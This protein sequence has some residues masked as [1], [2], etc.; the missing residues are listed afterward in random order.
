MIKDKVMKIMELA[1][2]ICPPEITD[3]GMN[4]TAAFV[5]Y[6]PHCNSLDVQIYE[7]GWGENKQA[8]LR[9]HVYLD[10]AG[11]LYKLDFIIDKLMQYDKVEVQ[12]DRQ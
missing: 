11:A 4:H 5:Q 8:N 9:E 6:S 7:D 12:N 3:V 2:K 10:Q 1:L